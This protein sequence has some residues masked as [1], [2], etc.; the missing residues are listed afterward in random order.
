MVWRSLA[1]LSIALHIRFVRRVASRVHRIGGASAYMFQL[2]RRRSMMLP[3]LS[4]AL[5][6]SP[7][8]PRRLLLSRHY[9]YLSTYI[10]VFC[11]INIIVI[12][13][14]LALLRYVYASCYVA[15]LVPYVVGNIFYA[16]LCLCWVCYFL[17]QVPRLVGTWC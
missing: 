11:I 15:P 1:Q 3:L 10:I 4:L 6:P 2:A 14:W 5:S 7:F 13:I 16:I 17:P 8:S 12:A 9:N